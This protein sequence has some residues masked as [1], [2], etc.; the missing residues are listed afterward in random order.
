MGIG[1]LL[2]RVISSLTPLRLAT[3]SGRRERYGPMHGGLP[4][5][6]SGVRA[7]VSGLGFPQV[8]TAPLRV[9]SIYLSI[10]LSVDR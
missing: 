10:Y 1:P 3:C 9:R 7:R 6:P 2:L 8:S 4:S 5:E